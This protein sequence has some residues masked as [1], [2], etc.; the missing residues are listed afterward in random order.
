MSSSSQA[1]HA[2]AALTPARSFIQKACVFL[3][4]CLLFALA[5]AIAAFQIARLQNGE[6]LMASATGNAE[7]VLRPAMTVP[8]ALTSWTTQL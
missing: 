8:A 2:S 5:E 6:G 3:P 1:L 7:G 4:L